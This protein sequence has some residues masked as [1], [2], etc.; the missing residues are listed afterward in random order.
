[1]NNALIAWTRSD[2]GSEMY[3]TKEQFITTIDHRIAVLSSLEYRAKRA[4]ALGL[5]ITG[6]V[7]TEDESK[8]L[9]VWKDCRTGPQYAYVPVKRI[10]PNRQGQER[11]L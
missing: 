5:K 1:M 9:C 11:L 10:I 2:N 7:L 6:W 8:G 4:N 3:M